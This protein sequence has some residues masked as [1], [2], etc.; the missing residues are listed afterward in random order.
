MDAGVGA[1]SA[2][3][4]VNGAPACSPVPFASPAAAAL[5]AASAPASSTLVEGDDELR[6]VLRRIFKQYDATGD[7]SVSVGELRGILSAA[8]VDMSSDD[9]A[10]IVQDADT[11][12]SG[13]LEFEE[14]YAALCK[15]L[16]GSS[17]GGGENGSDALVGGGLLSI[18]RE[19]SSFFNF[20]FNPLKW[21]PVMVF[22]SAPAAAPPVATTATATA[23]PAAKQGGN[24]TAMRLGRCAR[25]APSSYR[26]TTSAPSLSS[27]SLSSCVPRISSPSSVRSRQSLVSE[28]LLREHNAQ[29]GVATRADESAR[30]ARREELHEAFLDRQHARVRRF[31]TQERNRQARVEQVRELK[32]QSGAALKLELEKSWNDVQR[33]NAKQAANV[34]LQ[35]QQARQAKQAEMELRQQEHRKKGQ[36]IAVQAQVDRARRRE[37]SLRT[38]RSQ[39]QAAKEFAER[40]KFETRPEVRQETREYFQAQRNAICASERET[41]EEHRWRRGEAEIEYLSRA[42]SKV[43]EVGWTDRNAVTSRVR[44]AERRKQDADGVRALLSAEIK[45]KRRNESLLERQRRQQHDAI[46]QERAVPMA[47][48]PASLQIKQ[49]DVQVKPIRENL[50]ARSRAWRG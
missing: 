22:A 36:Q 13:S 48:G 30:R 9:V 34:S 11:D 14:F 41:Q 12:S 6:S 3:A 23:A 16:N 8:S 26:L 49:Q 15:Q 46:M 50:K 39:E 42:L 35:V 31:R 2:A 20:S 40:V 47:T 32:R 4:Q 5:P 18:V 33:R 44:L 17:D 43:Y 37:D 21:V 7:G 38:V 10:K 1:I 25:S 45:R 28:A 29:L 19:S 24:A 27:S